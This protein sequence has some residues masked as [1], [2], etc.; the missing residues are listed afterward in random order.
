M[1]YVDKLKQKINQSKISISELAKQA[2]ISR[3]AIYKILNR[4]TN[5]TIETLESICNVLNVSI[6]E[7]LTNAEI[8]LTLKNKNNEDEKNFFTF[9]VD[10]DN[11]LP[12]IMKGDEALV[13]K[14]KEVFTNDICLV[15]V[16]NKQ[17][18]IKRVKVENNGI[19]L[20]D[21][22]HSKD[23]NIS[24]FTSSEFNEKVNVM[25]RVVEVRRNFK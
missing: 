6:N 13:K 7:I 21:D 19:I 1:D 11:M 8:D 15:K 5:S 9:I 10:S 14:Q 2:K 23:M 24:F 16:D 22:N 12:L 3:Q 4:Q 25:G 18:Q 20:L 17:P